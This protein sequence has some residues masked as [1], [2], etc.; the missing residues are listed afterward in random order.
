M[1]YPT[2]EE[3]A[4]IQAAAADDPDTIPDL[5]EAFATGQVRRVGRPKS[6]IIKQAV[7]IRLDQDILDH[8]RGTGAG[9]QTRLNEDLRR[10]LKDSAA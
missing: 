8:Y 3:D 9:W 6:A 5:D 1:A 10:L 7:S 2:P 4:A